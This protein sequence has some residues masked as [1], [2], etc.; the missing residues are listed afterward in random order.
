MRRLTGA[1]G[2]ILTIV[3]VTSCATTVQVRH[4]VPAEVDLNGRR[5]IAIASATLARMA[6]TTVVTLAG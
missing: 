5:E 1:I 4:L 2:L 3:L 6:S